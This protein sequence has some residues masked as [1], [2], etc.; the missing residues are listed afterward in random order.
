MI[1]LDLLSITLV[2]LA[3]YQLQDLR[4]Q[5]NARLTTLER[6]EPEKRVQALVAPARD[7]EKPIDNFTPKKPETLRPNQVRGREVDQN[8]YEFDAKI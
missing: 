2:T 7:W 4:K 1:L 6:R 5:H 8:V 3:L